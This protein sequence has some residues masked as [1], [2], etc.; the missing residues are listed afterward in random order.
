MRS[1]PRAMIA[2]TASTMMMITSL[3]EPLLNG[4]LEAQHLDYFLFA[5]ASESFYVLQ[6]F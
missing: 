5:S 6:E 1:A 3:L 4:Y 2:S